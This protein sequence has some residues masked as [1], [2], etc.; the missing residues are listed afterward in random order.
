M[1]F[2]VEDGVRIRSN[3]L[4]VA[5]DGYLK[6]VKVSGGA[7]NCL[8]VIPGFGKITSHTNCTINWDK[9]GIWKRKTPECANLQ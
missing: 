8:G 5:L 2:N 3:K 6:E 9:A 7:V 1:K 4:G